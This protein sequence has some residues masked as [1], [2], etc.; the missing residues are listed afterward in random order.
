MWKDKN[1][2]C[3][4]E[5]CNFFN[6]TVKFYTSLSYMMILYSTIRDHFMH[7]FMKVFF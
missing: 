1:L 2:S 4:V 5:L 6:S 7:V 3:G